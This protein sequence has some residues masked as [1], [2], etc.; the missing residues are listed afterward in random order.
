MFTIYDWNCVRSR[1]PP[2]FHFPPPPLAE[3]PGRFGKEN[4]S[5]NEPNPR[6]S[7]D[8]FGWNAQVDVGWTRGIGFHLE[9]ADQE[10]LND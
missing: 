1:L 8:P 5:A 2:T 6:G 9:V 4:A 3:S 7:D 10:Y